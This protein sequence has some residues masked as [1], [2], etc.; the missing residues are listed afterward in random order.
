[1]V[2]RFT[3]FYLPVLQILDDIEIHEINQLIEDV[4]NLCHLSDEDRQIMTN[5]G[6]QPRYR[7]NISWAV[8]DLSQAGFIERTKRGHYRINLAGLAM[9][10]DKPSQPTRDYLIKHSDK[11]REFLNKK[12]TRSQKKNDE[13]SQNLFKIEGE[14]EEIIEVEE[15]EEISLKELYSSMR[16]LRKAKIS[17]SEIEAKA[18]ELEEKLIRNKILPILSQQLTSALSE[19]ERELVLVLDYKPGQDVKVSL[20]RRTNISSALDAKELKMFEKKAYEIPSKKKQKSSLRVTLPDGRILSDKPAVE[21]LEKV[22]EFVGTDKV[23]K[24]KIISNGLPLI[25]KHK[26]LKYS[27]RRLSNDYFLTT[28]HT[29]IFKKNVIDSIS[30]KLNLKISCEIIN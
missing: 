11:F 2:P 18:S 25:G 7:S 10:D 28:N 5:S 6:T 20:S 4:A 16:T 19:I 22:I 26:P 30:K 27:Y 23:A 12:G 3:E 1:M 21:I 24:L 13:D 29:T 17:T 15:E 14:E 9:L 8:T